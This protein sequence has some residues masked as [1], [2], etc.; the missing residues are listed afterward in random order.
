MAVLGDTGL[1][2]SLFRMR[3]VVRDT[4]VPLPTPKPPPFSRTPLPLHLSSKIPQQLCLSQN[5]ASA[6]WHHSLTHSLTQL[7]HSTHWCMSAACQHAC[8]GK[9]YGSRVAKVL[10][11]HMLEQH[12]F[13]SLH[14]LASHMLEQHTFYSLHVRALGWQDNASINWLYWLF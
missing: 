1:A 10:A 5:V 7:T 2:S 4:T 3:V 8:G 14:V 11:S 12:T 9:L 13:Y 6:I